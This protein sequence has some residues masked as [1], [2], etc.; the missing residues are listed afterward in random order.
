[1]K[2]EDEALLWIAKESGG[3]L[4]DAYTLFDQVVSFSEGKIT[5]PSF[6]TSSASRAK[7]P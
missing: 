1:V 6:A 2:A 3:S 4:R 5:R 7:T